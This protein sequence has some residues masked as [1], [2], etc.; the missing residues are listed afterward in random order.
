MRAVHRPLLVAATILAIGVA[1]PLAGG[2][3]AQAATEVHVIEVEGPI[4]RPLR[5]YL[6]ERLAGAERAGA[7]VVLQLDTPGALGQDGIALAERVAHLEVPVLTWV[8]PV[9]ARASGAGLLLMLASSLAGVSPGSQTGPL[10]PVDVLH[11]D[12]ETE[13][14]TGKIQ[15]W[16]ELRGRDVDLAGIGRPL[17]AQAALD[18]GIAEASAY[19]V[20]ELLRAV[21]G[22]TVRTPGGEVELETRVATTQAEANERTVEIRFEEPGV[23]TRVLHA[24]ATPSMVY[25]LVVLGTAALA[26]ELTQPGFGFAGF[27]GLA[28][29]AL[30]VYGLTVAVPLWPG[31]GLL[32]LGIGLLMLDVRLRSLSWPTWGGL[33]AFGAGSVLAWSDVDPSIRIS[34]WLVGGAVL[35]SLLYYGF[36]LTV[37]L[38]S[39][40]RIVGTQ[41]GL[42]GMV[43][44]ARGRLAPDGPVFVKGALWRGRTD[45]DAIDAGTPIR[46]R[47][48]DGLILRVEA[49]PAQPLEPTGA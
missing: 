49:E 13:G 48:V 38:Q 29:A 27:S 6:E 9:P 14:L 45:G 28:L 42:I 15:R 12:R 31:F 17:A 16:L 5:T 8:G 26:F 10:L 21:D 24:V 25:F 4:D 22:M 2:A 33:A 20:P 1:G 30:A 46:V 7:I 41:R 34:L 43:G 11:P 19:T 3:A 32:M 40:D 47:G 44:E 37:A 23:I 18:A 39:R 36:A 35:A